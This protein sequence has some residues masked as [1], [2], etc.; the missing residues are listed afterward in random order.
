MKSDMNT[1]PNLRTT[2]QNFENSSEDIYNP[3]RILTHTLRADEIL[4]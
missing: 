2:T 4:K 1:L 3:V